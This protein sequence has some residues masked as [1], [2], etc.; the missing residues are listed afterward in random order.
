MMLAEDDKNEL[1]CKDLHHVREQHI[2]DEKA[3][4]KV[5]LP[6]YPLTVL[7]F[8]RRRF[9]VL[10]VGVLWCVWWVSGGVARVP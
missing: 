1:A 9:G 2:K 5:R 3:R 4:F 6:I 10:I 7:L 8:A